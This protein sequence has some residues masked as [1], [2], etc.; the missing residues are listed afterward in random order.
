MAAVFTLSQD[1]ARIIWEWVPCLARLAWMGS[2]TYIKHRWVRHKD[3]LDQRKAA[4]E[5]YAEVT[6]FVETDD[7]K[8]AVQQV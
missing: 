7:I 5:V 2:L 3:L 8:L 6:D 4:G 1:L